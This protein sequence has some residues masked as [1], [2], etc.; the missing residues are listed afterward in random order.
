MVPNSCVHSHHCF[1]PCLVRKEKKKV[2][3]AFSCVFSAASCGL[4]A[5]SPRVREVD[6]GLAWC[7]RLVVSE[8]CV[9]A[10]VSRF[11]CVCVCVLGCK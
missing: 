2:S 5:D 3:D 8:D 10:C 4:L 1:G 9:A 11:V 7:Q 6:E